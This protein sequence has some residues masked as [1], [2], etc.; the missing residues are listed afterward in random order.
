MPRASRGSSWSGSGDIR[1]ATSASPPAKRRLC[2]S[3]TSALGAAICGLCAADAD[4]EAGAAFELGGGAEGGQAKIGMLK[5]TPQTV[6]CKV[7]K[8]AGS[9]SLQNSDSLARCAKGG[10]RA[11]S[12]SVCLW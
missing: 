12:G 1:L 5:L 4:A 9:E 11:R 3:A 8:A 6:A 7:I 2:S 10:P